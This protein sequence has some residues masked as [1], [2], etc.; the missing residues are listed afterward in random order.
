MNNNKRIL[1][2]D[3]DEDD[4]FFFGTALEEFDAP[5]QFTY[6]RD[7][8]AAVK[9]LCNGNDDIPD[10]LFLDWNM[11]RLSGRECLVKIRS[12]PILDNVPVI[13]YTTS[14]SAA[15]KKEAK[16]LGAS[17]FLSKPPSIKLLRN[18]LKNLISKD[19]KV[20]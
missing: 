6:L 11:P 18:E 17:Y 15:D 5:I 19:W 16:D 10:L 14:E 8:E 20:I 12:T 3:D 1:L 2:I 13:I 7:S 4:C 9:Q